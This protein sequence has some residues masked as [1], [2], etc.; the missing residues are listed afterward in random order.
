MNHEEYVAAQRK[1]QKEFA[2]Q[3]WAVVLAP[4]LF[5][6]LILATTVRPDAPADPGPPPTNLTSEGIHP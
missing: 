6:F 4:P 3:M 1:I 5:L 2:M